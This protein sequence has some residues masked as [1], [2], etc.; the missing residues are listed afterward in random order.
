MLKRIMSFHIPFRS[1]TCLLC[2]LTLHLVS[3]KICLCVPSTILFMSLSNSNSVT[4]QMSYCHVA[5]TFLSRVL[6]A[7]QP[8]RRILYMRALSNQ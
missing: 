7:A 5:M 3:L 2:H 4:L 1:P 8:L 6:A